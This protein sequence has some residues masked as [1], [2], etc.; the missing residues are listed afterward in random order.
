MR[1][2]DSLHMRT[3]NMYDIYVTLPRSCYLMPLAEKFVDDSAVGSNINVVCVVVNKRV[4]GINGNRLK[5]WTFAG[6][7]VYRRCIGCHTEYIACSANQYH[8]TNNSIYF[9][10]L[11]S[12]FHHS[13]YRQNQ[14]RVFATVGCDGAVYGCF[15]MESN[16]VFGIRL[17]KW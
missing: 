4:G 1:A 7:I 16:V 12:F 13:L 10:F 5:W 17:R 15:Q 11:H 14:C 3:S 2:C 9:E 6:R 8:K